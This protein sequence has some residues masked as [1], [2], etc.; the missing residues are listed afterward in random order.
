MDTIQINKTKFL[1]NKIINVN[2]DYYKNILNKYDLIFKK[3]KCF[4]SKNIFNEEYNK[5]YTKKNNNNKWIIKKNIDKS[6]INILNILNE[7]NYTKMLDRIKIIKSKNN[8]NIIVKEILNNCTK[9]SFYLKMYI[10]FIEDILNFS[11][12]EDKKTILLIINDY[13]SKSINVIEIYL[14]NN[15]I[16]S[17]IEDYDNFCDI[18]KQKKEII[19]K[20]IIIINLFKKFNTENN[21]NYYYNILKNV[22]NTCLNEEKLILIIQLLIEI[23][24]NDNSINI[25][26]NLIND[27]NNKRLNFFIEELNKINTY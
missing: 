6:I 3:Y 12:D 17:S 15:S 27:T 21:L 8:L 14:K 7:A 9:Q 22:L 1:E 13:I 4:S 24:T 5:N 2:E 10:K 20:N 25:N 11:I 26:V 19:S 16:T 18:Q 23:K